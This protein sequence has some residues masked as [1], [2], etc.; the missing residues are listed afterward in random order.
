MQTYVKP[1]IALF[2]TGGTID[3]VGTDRLDLA[4]Y[5]DTEQRLDSAALLERVPELSSFASVKTVAFSRL[6]SSAITAS[7]WLRLAVAVQDS[8]SAADGVVI[9]HGTN[10]LEET[11]YFLALTIKTSKPIV[12]TGSM[13]PASAVSS[14][15]DLNLINAVR[16]AASPGASGMGVLVV[17]N[18]TIHAA[19][20]VTKTDT[21][22]V[23]TFASGRSGP[24]G[25]AD[26]DGRVVFYRAPVRKHT[27]R[28]AF[29]LEGLSSLPRV[30]IVASYPDQDGV[31]VDALVAAG[32][33]GIVSAGTGA[34]RTTPSET[35]ALDRAVAAG[36]V[37]VQCSR[38]GNGRVVRSPSLVRRRIV[39]ADDLSPWKARVLLALALTATTELDRIQTMFDEY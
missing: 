5:G 1:A 27:V 18:D 35:S 28:T 12:V 15:V 30:D 34:G 23:H 36:V 14:D 2:I 26:A 17:L 38:V 16:V 21:Y 6:K 33:E 19:R 24:L 10:T 4:E 11:A 39:A 31:M 29:N 32:A 13:R 22:R 20:E 7:D 25:F 37:V 9:T 8:L 3:S